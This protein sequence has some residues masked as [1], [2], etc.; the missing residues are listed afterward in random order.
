MRAAFA[1]DGG[2]LINTHFGHCRT[3]MIYEITTERFRWMETRKVLEPENA[4]ESGRI[5]ARLNAITDCTLVFV[6][7]IGAS[8]AAQVTRS[9]I[10]PVK[11]DHETEIL[12]QLDRL[13][14]MLQ[15]KPPLWLV[16]AMNESGG[17]GNL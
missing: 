17:S 5:Q 7:A 12:Q 1:T 11:V 3:F 13:L 14:L 10:M 8:G 6:T 2:R 9:K 4:D 16:K 15:T